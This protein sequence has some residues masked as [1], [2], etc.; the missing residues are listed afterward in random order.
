MELFFGYRYFIEGFF[1]YELVECYVYKLNFILYMKCLFVVVLVIKNSIENLE[2]FY[3]NVFF[4]L[5]FIIVF[6]NLLLF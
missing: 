4:C 1:V 5:Y 2:V 6:R 3:L